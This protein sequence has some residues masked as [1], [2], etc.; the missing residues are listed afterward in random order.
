MDIRTASE[1]KG[2]PVDVL[3]VIDREIARAGGHYYADGRDLIAARAAVAELI[4]AL[5]EAHYRGL[6]IGADCTWALAKLQREG[7][8]KPT[9]SD[10][11]PSRADASRDLEQ[12]NACRTKVKCALARIGGAL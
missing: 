12:I 8:Y 1:T 6:M 9:C 2:A 4:E 11:G 3:A 7:I 10:G 5:R